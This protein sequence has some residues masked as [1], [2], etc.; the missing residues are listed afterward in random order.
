[1]PLLSPRRRYPRPTLGREGR[2]GRGNG[3]C[4][5]R[6]VDSG[7][8]DRGPPGLPPFVRC[9]GALTLLLAG[10]SFVLF[11]ILFWGEAVLSPE[12]DVVMARGHWRG[13]V[14]LVIGFAVAAGLGLHVQRLKAGL[15][16][17]LAGLLFLGLALGTAAAM[18]IERLPM[19]P[20]VEDAAQP[21][22]IYSYDLWWPPLLIWLSA[23]F[24]DGAITI[25]GVRDRRARTDVPGHAARA[26]VA[27]AAR[28]VF[29]DPSFGRCC[30]AWPCRG[31]ARVSPARALARLE[32]SRSRLPPRF[33]DFARPPAARC[34]PLRH[35]TA[36]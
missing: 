25:L 16:G 13:L 9:F 3:R 8:Q 23:C 22:W 36:Q 12:F 2:D 15:P 32:H 14:T 4:D 35:G 28:Q 18:R 29:T 27:R 20:G 7:H 33:R 24:L 6:V 34:P 26:V 21:F 30:G 31:R 5:R 11:A 19:G 10:L 1:M 17:H